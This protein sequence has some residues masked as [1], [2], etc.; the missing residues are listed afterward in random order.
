MG[1]I[2]GLANPTRLPAPT[3]NSLARST[4]VW[5]ATG[6]AAR[7]A[8]EDAERSQGLPAGYTALS[9]EVTVARMTSLQVQA[10]RFKCVGNGLHGQ[11]S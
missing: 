6:R 10:A 3:T 4:I 5:P 7:L 11:V 2:G 8:I 9:P 1:N